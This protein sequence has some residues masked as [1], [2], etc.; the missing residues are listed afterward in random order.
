VPIELH[1]ACAESGL[2]LAYV[3]EPEVARELASGTVES[4]LD[5][6]SLELTGLFLYYARAARTVPRL[7]EFVACARELAVSS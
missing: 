5:E 1:I 3:A 7:K 6:Y 4:V 2:G